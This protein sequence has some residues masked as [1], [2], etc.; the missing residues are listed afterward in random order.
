MAARAGSS[1]VKPEID[2]GTVATVTDPRP[3]KVIDTNVLLSD[4]QALFAFENADVVIT[5]TVIRELDKKKS[6]PDLG[7]TA[8]ETLR[9]SSLSSAQDS[10][11]W[12][13]WG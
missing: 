5:G 9:I 11:C 7:Y 2:G 8:R 1:E 13:H 4:P 3:T 12:S 10:C 6:D